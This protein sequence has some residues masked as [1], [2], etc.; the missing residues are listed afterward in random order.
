MLQEFRKFSRAFLYIVIAAFVGTI[1][2]AWGADITRSK[3]Q[4]GIVGEVDGEEIDYRDYSNVVDNYYQRASSQSQREIS[5]EEIVELR[6]RAWTDLVTN[7]VHKHI[8]DRLGLTTTKV[9][10]S[11]HLRRYPPQFIQQHPEFPETRL[12]VHPPCGVVG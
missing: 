9:E 8:F 3:G 11:E 7:I 4:K 12:V 6:N 5:Q 10:L 2:F 1:I